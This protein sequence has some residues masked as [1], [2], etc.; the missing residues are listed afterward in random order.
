MLDRHR[1]VIE[2]HTH[3]LI[4]RAIS[5]K[6]HVSFEG[7]QAVSESAA[8]VIRNEADRV[9]LVLWVTNNVLPSLYRATF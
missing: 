8:L 5:V 1:A 7:D 4:G 2:R 3:D 9:R 6:A